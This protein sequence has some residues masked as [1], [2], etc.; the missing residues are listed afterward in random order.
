MWKKLTN[1]QVQNLLDDV[2][3]SNGDA[4]ADILFEN[5]N[6]N[7]ISID[8]ETNSVERSC[9]DSFIDYDDE[10]N[11]I[12]VYHPVHFNDHVSSYFKIDINNADEYEKII[13]MKSK[14]LNQYIIDNSTNS[15]HYDHSELEAKL[16]EF[17][18]SNDEDDEEFHDKIMKNMSEGERRQYKDFLNNSY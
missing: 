9:I 1:E 7:A 6:E 5:H 11:K 8:T 12:I 16:E 18:K 2:S 15:T 14:E 10:R 4:I 17:Y 13:N 3:K